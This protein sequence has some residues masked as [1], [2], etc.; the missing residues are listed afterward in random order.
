MQ[1]RQVLNEI[2]YDKLRPSDRYGRRTAVVFG[3]AALTVLLG[4]VFFPGWSVTQ[5]ALTVLVV[6][7]FCF[8]FIGW[9]VS[10]PRAL[11][12][13]RS[14]PQL[15]RTVEKEPKRPDH[16]SKLLAWTRCGDVVELIFDSGSWMLVRGDVNDRQWRDVQRLLVWCKRVPSRA[17]L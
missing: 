17:V 6:S 9:L 13:A 10:I 12:T 16:H 3:M 5:Q 8:G 7:G 1:P 11:E 4:H 15:S 2:P 14:R